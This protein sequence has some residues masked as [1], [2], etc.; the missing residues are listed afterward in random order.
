M[1]LPDRTEEL[2]LLARHD[3]VI[4]I[5]EVGRGALA[6]PVCVGAAVVTRATPAEFPEGLRDSKLLSAAARE[7]LVAPIGAWLSGGVAVGEASPA[8]IDARG[9]M[10]AMR[11]AATRALAAISARGLR[12][13]ALLLDGSHDWLQPDLFDDVPAFAERRVIVKGDARCAVVAAA[14]VV[15]KVHRDALMAGTPDPGYGWAVHKG[16]G[17]AAHLAAL[18][19]LGPCEFHRRSWKLAR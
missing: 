14:S 16:Y 5:D 13:T 10:G 19:E 18:A 3:A 9:I 6:G 15:A 12:P 4:G 7:R 17:A 1:I 8:E 11:L 2:A